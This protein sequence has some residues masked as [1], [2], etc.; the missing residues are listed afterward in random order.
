MGSFDKQV[1]LVDQIARRVCRVWLVAFLLRGKQIVREFTPREGV[2]E[3]LG[4]VKSCTK[5]ADDLIALL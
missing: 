1:S 3:P 4:I 2:E 5:L